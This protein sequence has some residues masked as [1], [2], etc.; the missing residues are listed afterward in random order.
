[1]FQI[2][3]KNNGFHYGIFLHICFYWLF[4]S[5][6]SPCLLSSFFLPFSNTSIFIYFFRCCITLLLGRQEQISTLHRYGADDRP[7]QTPP[8]SSLMDELVAY[9]KKSGGILKTQMTQRQM[10]LQKAS[11]ALVT[12]RIFGVLLYQPQIFLTLLQCVWKAKE[13]CSE[14]LNDFNAHSLC[15]FLQ[16]N[17]ETLEGWVMKTQWTSSVLLPLKIVMPVSCIS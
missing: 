3:L 8:E 6:P 5:P 16:L 13:K 11:P 4:S 2:S 14:C 9:K 1:M 10:H 15:R 17:P 12:M 7:I